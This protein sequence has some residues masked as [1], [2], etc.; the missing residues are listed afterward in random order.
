LTLV[1]L[2][3]KKGLVLALSSFN[4]KITSALLLLLFRKFIRREGLQLNRN[5]IEMIKEKYFMGIGISYKITLCKCKK[6]EN[7]VFLNFQTHFIQS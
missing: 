6:K 1:E 4:L 3:I 2:L 5:S 7:S